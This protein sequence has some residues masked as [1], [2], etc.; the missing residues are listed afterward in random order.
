MGRC[1]LAFL[2]LLGPLAASEPWSKRDVAMETTYQVLLLMDWRQTSDFH[3]QGYYDGAGVW[4]SVGERNM[5]LGSQPS[6][7]KINLICLASSLGHLWISNSLSSRDRVMWQGLTIG[8]E[9]LAVSNNY[10]IGVRV[11]F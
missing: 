8:V 1:I 5:F 2:L 6:Q 11:T 7:A 9:V 4:R 3:K 10:K